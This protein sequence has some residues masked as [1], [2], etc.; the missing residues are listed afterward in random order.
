M[1]SSVPRWYCLISLCTNTA[2]L[3]QWEFQGSAA[4]VHI[5][6][7]VPLQALPAHRRALVPLLTLRLI[8]FLVA[9]V[10]TGSLFTVCSRIVLGCLP[11]V[12]PP[13]LFLAVCLVRA[14]SKVDPAQPGSVLECLL[15]FPGGSGPGTSWCST[16]LV[17]QQLCKLGEDTNLKPHL[18]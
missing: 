9:S 17:L 4:L 15:V 2:L 1:S 6:A 12:P 13:V 10:A 14:I 8:L 5:E 3:G 18:C 7:A 11:A 16:W